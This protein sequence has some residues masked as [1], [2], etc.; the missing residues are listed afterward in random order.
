MDAL[1]PTSG[2]DVDPVAIYAAD[3][4]RSRASR[5]WVLVN[6]IATADGSAVDPDGLSGGLGGPADKAVFSAIRG[7]ADVVVAGAATVIAEDYG[8][9]RPP[10][11]IRR[12]RCRRGQAEAPRIAVVTASLSID[13]GRRLFRESPADAQPIVL[14]VERADPARRQALAAVAEVRDAGVDQVDWRRAI[15]VLAELTGARTVLCEGGPTT[16]AQLVSDDLVDELCL[17]VAPTMIAGPGPRIA[18][19]PLVATGRRLVLDR[20][21]A[22]GDH[23]FLRYVRDRTDG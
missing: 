23:L 17:T 19:S 16:V 13:P 14:T 4:R 1:W 22:D 6:M 7:V 12:M 5:P 10:A 18:Q 9:A 11:A 3:D 15:A 21:L 2:N 20:V 8:P